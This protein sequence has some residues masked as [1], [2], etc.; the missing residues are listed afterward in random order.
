[1]SDSD[2]ES[3]SELLSDLAGETA[4]SRIDEPAGR[5]IT[6]SGRL[7]AKADVIFGAEGVEVNWFFGRLAWNKL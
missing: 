5:L 7:V 6:G 3:L 4:D 1:V 2:R